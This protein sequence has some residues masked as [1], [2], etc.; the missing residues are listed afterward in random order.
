MYER[1]KALQGVLL[2]ENNELQHDHR[3][4]SYD[5]LPVMFN[6]WNSGST[7][8]YSYQCKKNICHELKIIFGTVF[9]YFA[10][11]PS[12]CAIHYHQ[13]L[14]RLWIDDLCLIISH[15]LSLRAKPSL[16]SVKCSFPAGLM[17][18]RLMTDSIERCY[19]RLLFIFQYDIHS[20]MS[21]MCPEWICGYGF[22]VI[23]YCIH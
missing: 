4:T 23:I 12:G 7:I 8:C 15:W 6:S 10:C 21:G 2:K 5:N 14:R 16:G 9:I 18:T 3:F 11:Q 22:L 13:Q 1:N 19:Y 20:G 17:L